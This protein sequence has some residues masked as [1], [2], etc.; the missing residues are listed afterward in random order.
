M[1]NQ[2]TTSQLSKYQPLNQLDIEHFWE[3]KSTNIGIINQVK[4]INC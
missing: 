4:Y 3:L 1:L 2:I